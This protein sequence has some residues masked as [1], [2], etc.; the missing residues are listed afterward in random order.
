VSA[1]HT[2]SWSTAESDA[3]TPP[4]SGKDGKVLHFS[5]A[6]RA[7]LGKAAR[8]EVPRGVHGEWSAPAGRRDPVE[9]LEEQAAS[10]VPELM[11]IRYGRMLVSPFASIAAR[12]T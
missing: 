12:H 11:P 8:A 3:G 6:E 1:R 7:A 2:R 9:L 5:V 4:K 10:R